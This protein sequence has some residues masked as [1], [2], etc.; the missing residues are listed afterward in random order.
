MG[1]HAW[2]KKNLGTPKRCE[3]CG[4]DN[5]TGKRIHW[6]NISHE[7]RRDLSDWIRLC[8]PCHSHYD[9][10]NLILKIRESRN[11]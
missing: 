8:A 9:R 5:L 1:L 3:Q 7:Y 11:V 4:R 6:A 10:G 2:V